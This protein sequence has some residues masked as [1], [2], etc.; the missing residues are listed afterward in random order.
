MIVR[1]KPGSDIFKSTAHALVVPVN[2]VGTM[3]NGLAKAFALRYPGLEAEYKRACR[4]LVY[5]KP[6]FSVHDMPG[7]PYRKIIC[8]PTKYDW[9]KDSTIP[10][11]IHSLDGLASHVEAAG[12]LSIAVPALGCGKGKL[13]WMTV[14]DLIYQFLDPLDIEVELYPP[15]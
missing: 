5:K 14:E 2:T 8:L 6:G 3:G 4:T 11:L 13:P 10:I 9:R 12:I 15:F 1:M 7:T